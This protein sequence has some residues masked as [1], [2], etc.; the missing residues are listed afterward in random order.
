MYIGF[1][2]KRK[3]GGGRRELKS[4]ETAAEGLIAISKHKREE[5]PHRDEWKRRSLDDY[6]HVVSSASNKRDIYKVYEQKKSKAK[7]Y[8]CPTK[9]KRTKER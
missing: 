9:S 7:D 1:K 4:S 8:L 2:H 5:D 6:I 3:E